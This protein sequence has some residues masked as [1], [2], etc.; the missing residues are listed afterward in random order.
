[1]SA[2]SP[3]A[4][5]PGLFASYARSLAREVGARLWLAVVVLVAIGLL[6]GSGLLMLVPLL[7]ALGFS[8]GRIAG[9]IP[10][11]LSESAEQA[12]ALPLVLGALIAIKAAQAALR[13]WSGTLTLRI[14]TAFV[15]LLRERFY[16][17]LI[18]ADWLFLARQRASDLSQA[19]LE[20]LPAIGQATR[21]LLTLGSVALVALVQ[22]GV[23]LALSPA[24]TAF[25]LGAG[26]VV[27][28]GLRQL[29]RH[30]FALG[31][32]GVAQR[33]EMAASV[34]EHLAG[35]KLAKSHGRESRHF[36]LFRRGA[37]AIAE[38]RLRL[39][40]LGALTG[41][42]LEVGAVVALSVFVWFAVAVRHVPA[43][44]LLVLVFVFTRLLSHVTQMQNLWHAFAE[45]LPSFAATERTR[46]ALLAAA[47]PPAPA[48]ALPFAVRDAIRLEGVAFRY[49]PAQP[50]WALREIDLVIPARGVL[51]LCGP[52]G[53]G[54]STLADI[55]L[56]LLRPTHGRVLL[57]GADLAG[58]L[59]EWRASI[60][61]VPQET[62][63]FH[64]TIRANLLWA[65]PDAAET[66]LLA[67]LRAAAAEEF[68]R[69]LPLGL[70]TIVGDRGVRLSGGERQ[71]L[72]LARALL[73]RPTLLVLDEATSALDSPSERLVQDAVERLRGEFTLVVIAH[74]LSTVRAADH[75]VVLEGGRIAESG[76]W[77]ELAA[78]DGGAF[79]ALLAA[80][81]LR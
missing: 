62:F 26:A 57:D 16:R 23:A 15:T 41:V 47:E 25:A 55:L 78:R 11:L 72:A 71:R 58:R 52:S 33:T 42:W 70:D 2:P 51:A 19:L 35:L 44:P 48:A 14:E 63:L 28:L 76:A 7:H 13:A 30:S 75:I 77:D 17:A 43:A 53:A 4:D 60:G 10:G 65:R 29:R 56:G 18:A 49:D 50:A 81:E 27:G 24:M 74:R 36:E 45:S 22:V 80:A 73:R 54:K 38:H 64:E 40:R 34:S 3:T 6:E 66:D 32:T 9:G 1:M 37:Q 61:Y 59:H 67:A 79:R 69:R 5:L 20:E 31:K 68:V 8:G 12:R 39:Q 46:A 21:Q